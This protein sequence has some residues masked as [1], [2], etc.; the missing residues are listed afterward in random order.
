MLP[1]A[2]SRIPHA[3]SALRT[4]AHATHQLSGP[5]LLMSIASRPR[6]SQASSPWG[7]DL[8]TAA[9]RTPDAHSLE[10][11]S[12]ADASIYE[13]AALASVM[14]VVSPAPSTRQKRAAQ[15]LANAVALRYK[16]AGAVI[17]IQGV[18]NVS[19][20]EFGSRQRKSRGGRS[21]V[22]DRQIPRDVSDGRA[23]QTALGRCFSRT[24][25]LV[26]HHGNS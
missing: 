14:P 23:D 3:L 21:A 20:C 12:S 18:S 10:L 22:L 16:T 13:A 9:S 17:N 11:A 25:H 19:A 2:A 5:T 4:E 8:A 1:P 24:L 15:A 26:R 6:S 7:S